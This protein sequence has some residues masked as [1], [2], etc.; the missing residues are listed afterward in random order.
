MPLIVVDERYAVIQGSPSC[1]HP[2][3]AYGFDDP[4]LVA[5]A[6]AAFLETWES[7]VPLA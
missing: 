3:W 5:L 6:A 4:R 7:A 2:D 1:R